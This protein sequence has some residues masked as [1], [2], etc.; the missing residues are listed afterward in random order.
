MSNE[1][2]DRRPVVAR[3][4]HGFTHRDVYGTRAE[5]PDKAIGFMTAEMLDPI[6]EEA[7]RKGVAAVSTEVAECPLTLGIRRDR[8]SEILGQRAALPGR[9]VPRSA[10][11]GSSATTLPGEALR[12]E[13]EVAT[14]RRLDTGEAR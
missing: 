4:A 5:I 2:G 3:R 7:C 6:V 9:M 11:N 10:A 8:H 13:A 1:L 12:N 14:M